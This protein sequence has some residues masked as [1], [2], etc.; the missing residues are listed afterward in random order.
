[1][2]PSPVLTKS[3][4]I[5][6]PEVSPPNI[7]PS[8]DNI[9]LTY[10]S[11]TSALKKLIPSILLIRVDSKLLRRTILGQGIKQSNPRKISIPLLTPKRIHQNGYARCNGWKRYR[12][13]KADRA[14]LK[15]KL[16]TLSI[17]RRS[18][19]FGDDFFLFFQ[20]GFL[21]RIDPKWKR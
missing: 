7:Q 18:I 12:T 15:H 1:M 5:I 13:A 11:P 3:L 6:W 8:S 4:H 9:L 20:F 17:F 21:G 10:L 14:R 19:F 2:F 16:A